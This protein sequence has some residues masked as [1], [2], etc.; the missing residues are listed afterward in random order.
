VKR[1]FVDTTILTDA[2]LK[3]GGPKTAAVAALARF[4]ESELPVY[5]IKE[6][7][8]GPLQYLVWL[9]NKVVSTRSFT[10]TF[11]A[12]RKVSA[13]RNRQAT[14]LEV[15]ERVLAKMAGDD[16]KVLEAKYGARAKL[17]VIQADLLKELTRGLV[18][19]AWRQHRKVTTRTVQE[20]ACYQEMPPVLNRELLDLKPLDCKNGCCL[21]TP[22][23]QMSGDAAKLRKRISPPSKKEEANRIAALKIVEK[24]PGRFNER[25]C[26]NLGDAYFSLFAPTGSVILTTNTGDHEKL[27][28]ALGK[29]V[30]GP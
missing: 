11:T 27:A 10:K 19:R 5:A 16:H 17:D 2:T 22:L 3:P 6:F 26:R 8:R 29:V 13:Q 25:D 24:S 14:A 1:A 7:K 9:H 23:R 30:E 15:I 4:D 18:L 20:L 28:G 12:V 21:A